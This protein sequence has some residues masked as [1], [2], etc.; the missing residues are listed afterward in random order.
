MQ[1]DA[2]PGCGG[3]IGDF[4]LNLFDRRRVRLKQELSRESTLEKERNSQKTPFQ[5]NLI[6][7]VQYAYDYAPYFRSL[8][9]AEA[10]RPDEIRTREDL[11]KIPVTHK[12]DLIQLQAKNPPLGGWLAQKAGRLRRVFL[13]PGPIF[14]PE[15]DTDDFWHFEKAL[16]LAGFRAG[17][18]VQN[19]FSYHMT[20]GGFMLDAGLRKLGCVVF[21]AGVG[22]TNLQVQAAA[23]LKITG[24]TGTPSFLMAI[25]KKAEEMGYHPKRDLHYRAA[26]VT[27]E[28]LPP[29]LRERFQ[30][31]Y[32]IAVYQVYATADIGC[33]GFECGRREGWHLSRETLVQIC[34]P[35]SGEE[36]PPGETGEIVV[37]HFDPAY[38]LIRFGTGDLSFQMK[39]P[40]PCGNSSPRLGGYMGR[41]GEGIKV[42]GMFVHPN[43]VQT[44]VNPYS[45]VEGFQMVVSRKAH[46]DVLTYRLKNPDPDSVSAELTSEL[47]QKLRDV[48]KVAGKIEWVRAFEV[49]DRRIIDL[50]RWE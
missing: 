31:E 2:P 24:Y 11:Q 22:N 41:I 35:A 6:E 3:T 15:G 42:K 1:K 50:R 20:P 49:P 12:D 8:L 32:S 28:P 33:A 29:S 34:D 38:P 40:C 44:V 14:D 21:P 36:L 23:A 26:L 47:E 19:T 18:I 4:V 46:Q 37:T 45:E 39:D 10:V 48:V 30:K 13:S 43:Q 5:G 7:L 16:R 25:L 27:G 9:D 17:D